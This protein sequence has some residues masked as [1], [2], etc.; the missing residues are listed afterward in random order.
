[1]TNTF[2]FFCESMK[3]VSVVRGLR[4]TRFLDAGLEGDEVLA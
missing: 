3:S 4:A 1:M 2:V